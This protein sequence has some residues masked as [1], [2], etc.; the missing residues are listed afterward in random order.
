[1]VGHPK[2]SLYGTR[3]AA[4]SSQE[5]VA[6]EMIR[7]EFT[8]GKNNPCWFTH[9]RRNLITFLR[10]DDFATVGTPGGVK[11]LK[12][13]LEKQKTVHRSGGSDGWQ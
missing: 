12:E 13:A 6:K 4:M 1:M 5:L 3:D 11:W 10:G 2:M 8:R 9:P 7:I